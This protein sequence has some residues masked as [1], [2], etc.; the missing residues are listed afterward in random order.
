MVVMA[1]KNQQNFEG[2][3]KG[4]GNRNPRRLA[5]FFVSNQTKKHDMRWIYIYISIY[6]AKFKSIE[7]SNSGVSFNQTS[8]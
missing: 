1:I 6:Q 2:G 8:K 4:G 3:V 5:V 7:N